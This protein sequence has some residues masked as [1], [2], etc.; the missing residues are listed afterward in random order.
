LEQGI[1]DG[2]YILRNSSGS[3][4]VALVSVLAPAEHGNSDKLV[5]IDEL[6]FGPRGVQSQY[7]QVQRLFQIARRG[8]TLRLSAKAGDHI[9]CVDPGRA[10]T[11]DALAVVETNNSQRSLYVT[12]VPAFGI[13]PAQIVAMRNA[14]GARAAASKAYEES[15]RYRALDGSTLAVGSTVTPSRGFAVDYSASTAGTTWDNCRPDRANPAQLTCSGGTK[16]NL[17]QLLPKPP[18]FT[19]FGNE[20]QRYL[21][22]VVLSEPRAARIYMG[23]LRQGEVTNTALDVRA[24]AVPTIRL[25]K[26]G[27]QPCAYGPQWTAKIIP[28]PSQTL[29]AKCKMEPIRPRTRRR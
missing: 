20:S 10:P 6:E 17:E 22:L 25:E 26:D 28:G 14:I 27:Y 19:L 29:E 21:R 15:N 24:E 8:S 13:D 5:I 16:I 9:V 2:D 23:P 1:A 7:G 3:P 18:P 4:G 11:A 12:A